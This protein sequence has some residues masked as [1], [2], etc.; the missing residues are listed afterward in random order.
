MPMKPIKDLAIRT[1]RDNTR[2]AE[3]AN[4]SEHW[5]LLEAKIT[6]LVGDTVSPDDQ[7]DPR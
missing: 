2:R 6:D 7:G 5:A 4:L 3:Y 1:P